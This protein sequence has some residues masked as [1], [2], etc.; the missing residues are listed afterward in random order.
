MILPDINLLLYAYDSSAPVHPAAA[1]WWQ[2]CLS[3]SEPVGL[4]AVV[5]FGFVRLST[6]PRVYSP[7]ASVHDA[8]AR[9][10]SWL[11]RPQVEL[12]QPGPRHVE[13]ALNWLEAVGVGANLTT[14]AQIAATAMEYDATVHTTDADFARFPGLRWVNPLL[15]RR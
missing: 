12:L 6:N 14:D 5:V 1:R 11:A 3:G 15:P 2:D 9:V 10:R 8:A 13:T 4:A 7:A